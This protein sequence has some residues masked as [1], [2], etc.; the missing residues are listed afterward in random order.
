M[1][2]TMKQ[3][4]QPNTLQTFVITG[5]KT[6]VVKNTQ[7]THMSDIFQDFTARRNFYVTENMFKMHNNQRQNKI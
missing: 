1:S 4:N 5:L 6:S 7:T 3:I 2:C